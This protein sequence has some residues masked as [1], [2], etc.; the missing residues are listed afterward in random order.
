MA[1]F[2][3]IIGT[4]RRLIHFNKI[5]ELIGNRFKM[6]Y[7]K[8]VSDQPVEFWHLNPTEG[9]R[10]FNRKIRYSTKNNF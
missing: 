9:R 5:A 10:L 3:I 2:T 4:D 1:A 6:F 8:Q 7:Q